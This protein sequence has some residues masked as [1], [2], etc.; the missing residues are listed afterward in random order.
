[1]EVDL[2]FIGR[3]FD[4]KGLK[5]KFFLIAGSGLLAR[6]F[7][8][9]FFHSRWGWRAV[10]HVELMFY[11]GVA[12]G[13]HVKFLAGGYQDPTSWILRIIGFV[14]PESLTQY[15]VEFASIFLA[16]LT[17]FLLYLVVRERFGEKLALASGLIHVFT[18]ESLALSTVSYT[19]D[20]LQLPL[21]LLLLLLASKY[22]GAGEARKKLYLISALLVLYFGLRVN[23]VILVGAGLCI[24]YAIQSYIPGHQRQSFMSSLVII[25]VFT[26][27]FLLPPVIKSYT[28]GLPQGE[29]G[30]LDIVPLSKTNFW[31]RFNVLL[32]LAPAGILVAYRR[33]DS[34]SILLFLVGVFS[35]FYMDRGSRFITLG[36]P[37]LAAHALEGWEKRYLKPTAVFGALLLGYSH[38]FL[39]PHPAFQAIYLAAAVLTVIILDS[40]KGRVGQVIVVFAILGLI[41]NLIHITEVDAKRIVTQAEYEA[42]KW[43]SKVDGNRVLSEWDLGYMAEVV[44]GKQSVSNPGEIRRQFHDDLWLMQEQSAKSLGQGKVS[45]VLVNSN[46]FN[47]VKQSAQ[48]VYYSLAGGLVFRPE[49]S[50]PVELAPYTTIYALRYN[51]ST[52]KYF[53]L[54][55]GKE[56]DSTGK[57]VYL[58]EVGQVQVPDS[59]ASVGVVFS[60]SADMKNVS[61]TI[62]YVVTGGSRQSIM[63]TDEI[64]PGVSDVVYW[65]NHRQAGSCSVDVSP[66]S[67]SWRYFGNATFTSSSAGN[68]SV[69]VFLLDGSRRDASGRPVALGVYSENVTSS[70][71]DEFT[72]EYGFPTESRHGKVLVGFNRVPGLEVVSERSFGPFY[73]GVRVLHAFC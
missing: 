67:G 32:I 40:Q 48:Q 28:G 56:D 19:H 1:M 34:V 35:A 10:N 42:L 16:S 68:Y 12:R 20:H 64:R 2:R 50:P 49:S 11:T 37:V 7:L 69:K 72:V 61:L 17:G 23:P 18:V 22:V 60:N 33:A 9:V 57:Q 26:G 6:I 30:S 63:L 24:V 3:W 46:N 27:V 38:F 8:S 54:V 52:Q 15:G 65:L 14:L 39:T 4:S 25:T 47:L 41:V 31:V 66:P 45:H 59:R 58:Y 73:N 55:W 29:A 5:K 62:S 51:K 36:L 21:I 70:A 44:S 13:T 71:G 53:R 43:L